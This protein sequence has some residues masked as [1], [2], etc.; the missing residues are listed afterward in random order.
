M[1]TSVPLRRLGSY[2]SIAAALGAGQLEAEAVRPSAS[3]VET[4]RFS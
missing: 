3:D 1:P 4:P 2:L